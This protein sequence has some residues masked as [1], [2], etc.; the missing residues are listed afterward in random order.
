[1]LTAVKIRILRFFWLLRVLLRCG[2]YCDL[3]FFG[4]LEN[5]PQHYTNTSDHKKR[6]GLNNRCSAYY[7][8]TAC[9]VSHCLY[10]DKG[11]VSDVPVVLFYIFARPNIVWH[12]SAVTI[13]VRLLLRF[14]IY[15]F[16]KTGGAATITV[17]LRFGKIRYL[18]S[19]GLKFYKPVVTLRYSCCPLFWDMCV[20][21]PFRHMLSLGT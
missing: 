13:A 10:I 6:Q 20:V 19:L 12:C 7:Y 2:C 11:Y 9:S 3:I 14:L 21:L 8:N 18:W 16:Q 1:M 4:T 17:R 5:I 15:F